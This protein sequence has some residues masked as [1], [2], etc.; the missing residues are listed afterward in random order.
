MNNE[1]SGK[2][3]LARN[4]F[5]I[6]TYFLNTLKQTKHNILVLFRSSPLNENNKL[7]PKFLEG[8]NY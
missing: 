6:E 3:C 5:Q 7:I 4:L 8:A 2:K 1:L